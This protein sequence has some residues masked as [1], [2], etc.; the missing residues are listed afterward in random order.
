MNLFYNFIKLFSEDDDT[1]SPAGS[2]VCV[3]YP[4]S[5]DLSAQ[6]ANTSS[7]CTRMYKSPP[8]YTENRIDYFSKPDP[9]Q[10]DKQSPC[11]SSY[12][13]PPATTCITTNCGSNSNDKSEIFPK[14]TSASNKITD[15]IENDGNDF[16]IS[17][18]NNLY[19][20]SVNQISQAKG[21]QHQHTSCYNSSQATSYQNSSSQNSCDVPSDNF[22]K[23]SQSVQPM[24]YSN[25]SPQQYGSTFF[26]MLQS[27]ITSPKHEVYPSPQHTPSSTYKSSNI[28]TSPHYVTPETSQTF[29]TTSPRSNQTTPYQIQYQ[30]AQNSSHNSTIS[31]PSPQNSSFASSQPS[32]D[33]TPSPQQPAYPQTPPQ[34]INQISASFSLAPGKYTS[35]PEHGQQPEPTLAQL[36]RAKPKLSSQH[37]S[38]YK[39][40]PITTPV[41]QSNLAQYCHANEGN[42]P[43]NYKETN[44]YSTSTQIGATYISTQPI[45]NQ[46]NQEINSNSNS[47]NYPLPGLFTRFENYFYRSLY[48]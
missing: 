6:E 18:A 13:Y 12:M 29:P 26:P 19:S 7:Q 27:Y 35:Q 37:H 11:S 5:F 47:T 34:N 40:Q 9:L 15:N 33:L 3:K 41:Q 45:I 24:Q 38:P 46:N 10:S 42:A 20:N 23:P 48:E 14:E 4:E 22:S 44:V 17:L 31:T 32:L 36:V 16:N 21:Q 1:P 25:M 39:L 2:Q 8:A 30:T 28:F 43:V